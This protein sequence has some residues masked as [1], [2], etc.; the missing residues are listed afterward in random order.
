MHSWDRACLHRLATPVLEELDFKGA[1]V[2]SRDAL[3][4]LGPKVHDP[5]AFAHVLSPDTRLFAFVMQRIDW[6]R[7]GFR[8]VQ[9]ISARAGDEQATVPSVG[10]SWALASATAVNGYKGAVMLRIAA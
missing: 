1:E 4:R 7:A 6:Q 8:K 10:I 2:P 9:T 5:V 3:E